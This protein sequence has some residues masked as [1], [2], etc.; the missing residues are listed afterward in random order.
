MVNRLE[1]PNFSSGLS[2]K[3]NQ[4]RAI[5][6]VARPPTTKPWRPGPRK[7]YVDVSEFLVRTQFTPRRHVTSDLGGARTP[8]RACRIMRHRHR[9]EFPKN[10]AGAHIESPDNRR[11]TPLSSCHVSAGTAS[12]L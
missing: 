6:V 11:I 4:R 1:V 3:R 7:R 12:S 2:I 5:Q 8:A 9:T 10:L